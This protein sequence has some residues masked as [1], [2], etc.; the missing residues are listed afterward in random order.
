M[1]AA[2][3]QDRSILKKATRIA[4]QYRL[5]FLPDE[6]EHIVYLPLIEHR[7]QVFE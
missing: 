3:C 2:G 5:I 1:L 7:E 6:Q 4:K